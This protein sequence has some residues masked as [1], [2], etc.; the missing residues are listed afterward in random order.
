MLKGGR[1]EARI[2]AIF[3]LMFIIKGTTLNHTVFNSQNSLYISKL[4]IVLVGNQP[5]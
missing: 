4:P 3:Y 2:K 5:R 1:T